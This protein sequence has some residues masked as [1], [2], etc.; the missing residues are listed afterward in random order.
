[1]NITTTDQGKIMEDKLCLVTGASRGIGYHIALGLAG[2]GAYVVLVGHNHKRGENASQRINAYTTKNSTDFMLADLSSQEQI[3][4]FA[5]KFKGKH[6]HLDV[7]VN[8]AGGF[9]LRREE[10]MDG[11]EMTFALNHMNYFSL[12]LSL[13]KHLLP[14][15]SARIVNVSSEAHRGE[16]MD[17][18]DLQFE[19]GY[20]AMRAY[21][22]SKLANLL[23]T[24][25]LSRRLLDTDVTVNAVHPGFVGTYLGKQDSLVRIVMNI[26]HFLFA[27]SPKEGAQT[28]VYLASSPRVEDVTGRYVIDRQVV[29]SSPA[30]YDFK[31]AKRLWEISEELSG[32]D[33]SKAGLSETLSD[34][35]ASE[36]ELAKG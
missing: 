34:I 6:D 20:N 8:N 28:P 27:K 1:M 32:L 30:S 35:E 18:A 13:L 16:S 25:E 11:M 9:F 23:F 4:R 33:T 22:R 7:L 19:N 14:S 3:R 29:R 15:G 5:E 10:S 12:T 17:F 36:Q 21:G 31:A 2:M 24:Y 26:L